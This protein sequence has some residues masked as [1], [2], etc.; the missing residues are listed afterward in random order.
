VTDG[1]GAARDDGFLRG[2]YEDESVRA[3]SRLLLYA[4]CLASLKIWSVFVVAGADYRKSVLR[5]YF[6]LLLVAFF[7]GVPFWIGAISSI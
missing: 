1:F 7:F 2:L 5:L 3:F 4:F 6:A